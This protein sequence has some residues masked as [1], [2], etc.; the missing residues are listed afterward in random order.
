MHPFAS[1]RAVVLA[2]AVGPMLAACGSSDSDSSAA[3]AG[4]TAQVR[5]VHASSDTG[6]VDV[7]ANG[8]VAFGGVTFGQA[9]SFAAVPAGATRLQVNP[10]GTA[11]SAI[12]VTP[13]LT[14]DRR[15]TV[16]ALGNSA[17]GTPAAEALGAVLI[18]DSG[19]APATGNVKVRVVHGAPTVQPVDIYVTAPSAALPGTP[20][21]PALAFRSVAP[22]S[23][24]A[25][26][27]VP[28]GD[29]RVRVTLAGNTTV[30]YDSGAVTLPAGGDLVLVAVPSRATASSIALLVVPGTGAASEVTDQRAEVR[31][32]HFSPDTPTVDAYLR[33]PGAPLTSLNLVAPDVVFGQASNFLGALPGTYR[34]SVALDTQ[35]TEA[36][37][38]DATLAARQDV[39]VFAIGLNGG[40]GA[41]ALRLR[42]Y[43][44]DR[45][46]PPA[47]RAKLRV[48]H[49][50]P[51]APAVDVVVLDGS[52]A[53]ATR[54]V[55]NLAFPDATGTY[56]DVAPGTYRVAVVPA[57][58]STPLLPAASGAGRPG[59][60]VTLAAGDVATALAIG[61]LGTA[62]ACSG[63]SPFQL[64]ALDD[65]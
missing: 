50:S 39:S 13:T 57:G 10:A 54:L 48:I 45:S 26:L 17:S 56:L 37:G 43:P 19:A 51:D 22:A 27:E 44:D 12:D 9:S 24:Q 52:G 33:T 42:A 31:I 58:A 28:G 3:P 2:T 7:R 16:V 49:L 18:E 40:T 11:T 6:A 20:T 55:R 14:A 59:V 41:Q 1:W 36:I 25:A 53:I 21:I 15:Y 60:D 38:L 65:N 4:P 47:G 30:T 61:C 29:Y 32:G 34:A 23:G 46:A 63:A 64:L 5:A 8:A 35:T 62:G